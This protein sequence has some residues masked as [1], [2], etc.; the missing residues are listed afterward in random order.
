MNELETGT[1]TVQYFASLIELY[2]FLFPMLIPF[3][4]QSGANLSPQASLKNII[5]Y[6]L[7]NHNPF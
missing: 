4:K 5:L 3:E 1:P 2:L 6:E 7:I